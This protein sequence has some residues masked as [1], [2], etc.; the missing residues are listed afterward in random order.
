MQIAATINAL[1]EGRIG[2]HAATVRFGETHGSSWKSTQIY[3][4][5]NALNACVYGLSDANIRV[6]NLIDFTG[7]C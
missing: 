5:K 4:K 3:V 6:L 7:S 1:A 2:M